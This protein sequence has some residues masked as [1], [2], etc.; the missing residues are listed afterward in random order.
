MHLF[1]HA[2]LLKNGELRVTQKVLIKAYQDKNIQEL[3]EELHKVRGGLTYLKL[4][5]LTKTMKDFHET[6][7]A[8]PQDPERLEKT[9]QTTIKAIERFQIAYSDGPQG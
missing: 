6:V 9:F 2:T 7:K 1:V 4:P 3:R 8:E 5:E